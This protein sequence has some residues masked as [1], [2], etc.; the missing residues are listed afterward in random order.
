[1]K[2]TWEIL[3]YS[4][5]PGAVFRKRDWVWKKIQESTLLKILFMA[6]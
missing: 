3:N 5:N 2:K 1:M 6:S 4:L